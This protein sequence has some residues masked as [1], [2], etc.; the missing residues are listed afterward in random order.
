MQNSKGKQLK[1][2]MLDDKTA[3]WVLPHVDGEAVKEKFKQRRSFADYQAF[4][5]LTRGTKSISGTGHS[6]Y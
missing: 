3:V 1:R 5:S 2:V 4:D 6:D